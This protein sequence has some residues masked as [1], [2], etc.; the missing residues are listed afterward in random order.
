M[1]GSGKRGRTSWPLTDGA[2][3]EILDN[4]LLC[5]TARG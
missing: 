3:A 5:R 2:R 1:K 4:A